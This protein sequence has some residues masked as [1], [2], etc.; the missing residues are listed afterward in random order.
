MVDWFNYKGFIIKYEYGGWGVIG[1][2]FETKEDA[3]NHIDNL[4][5]KRSLGAA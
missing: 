4:L 1:T 5:I 2:L 3:K